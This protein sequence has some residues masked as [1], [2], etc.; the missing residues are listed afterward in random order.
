[1]SD[2]PLT[3]VRVVDLTRILSGPFC[4]M[5][6]G[7]LGADVLKIESPGSGDPVRGQGN[8]VEGLSW[9]F[10]GFNRNK[11][12]VALDLRKPEGLAVLERLLAEADILTENY[13]PGVLDEMG[14]TE[15]R[16]AAINPNLIVVSVNGYG[17]TG[18]YA[19]RPA[20]DFIAQAM[21]GYMAT[22]GTPATGPLRTGPPLTDLI[23]GLYAALGAVAAFA[24]GR[25]ACPRNGSRPR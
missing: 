22:N 6:L 23:A 24:G 1:M 14:L 19:D 21:S 13:R 15:E 20:F 17:S 11:R 3:G 16:L 2:L 7:D 25:R 18:P 12:S 8:I 9:Y 4:S 5:I 10:A